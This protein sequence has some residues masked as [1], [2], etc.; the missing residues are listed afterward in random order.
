MNKKMVTMVSVVVI[1]L[2]MLVGFSS[3]N[4]SKTT[5]NDENLFQGYIEANDVDINTKVPGRI[6]QIKVS[7][8]EIVK[9]G[10]PIAVIDAKDIMAKKEGLVALSKAAENGVEAAKAQYQAANGQLDAAEAVLR[11]AKN[12]A[13]GETVSK[14]KAAYDYL[15]TTYD[16]LSAVYKKGG[17]SKSKV[18]EIETKMNVAY[19][20]Y[21]M[22]KDGARN[23]DIIAASGQV[24]AARAMVAAASSNIAAS[25]DKY[26]QAL[27]GIKE[28]ETYL[29]D[30][31]IVSPL[32]GTVT[33]LNSSEGEMASTGMNIATIT[34]L[35]DM[36]VDIEIDE[37][38][39]S[40]FKVGDE[41]KIKTLAYKDK[42]IVGKVVRINKKA[43]YA[44]KKASNENGE[45][46]LVSYGVKIKINNDEELFRP[47]MTAI[48]DISK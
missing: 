46:D 33:L 25:E 34:D 26:A 15:K 1:A 3:V 41:V 39:L 17:V 5:L 9:K 29:T 30:A 38:Y 27:A 42:K 12:G 4:N 44:V 37:T 32:S 16:R 43:D 48:V 31:A 10:D 7:E 8:G 6:S 13:R 14:A 47:G 21:K 22:A 19:E 40:K 20:D 23:E 35:K 45:F 11:K 28:V 18:D 36:W 24:T 2:V